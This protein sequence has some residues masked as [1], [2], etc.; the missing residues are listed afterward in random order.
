MEEEG[1]GL[2]LECLEVGSTVDT[3]GSVAKNRPLLTVD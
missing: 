3:G 1:S 2:G